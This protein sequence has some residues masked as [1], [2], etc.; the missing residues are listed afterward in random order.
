MSGVLVALTAEMA[1][2]FAYREAIELNTEVLSDIVI[3]LVYA[4]ENLIRAVH[5]LVW[6]ESR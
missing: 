3:H 5:W 2:T 4:Q 6:W 1:I